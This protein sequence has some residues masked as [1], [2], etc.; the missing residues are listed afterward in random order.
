MNINKIKEILA[1]IRDN[2]SDT[3]EDKA[4]AIDNILYI[5]AIE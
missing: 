5:V 4:E 1:G 3:R 2:R